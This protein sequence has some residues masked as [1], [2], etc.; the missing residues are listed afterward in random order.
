VEVVES[1]CVQTKHD[2][3]LVLEDWSASIPKIE[4]QETSIGRSKMKCSMK[5]Q[6][7][8]KLADHQVM[9]PPGI[10][11][12]SKP[13]DCTSDTA[14]PEG[15]PLEPF[16]VSEKGALTYATQVGNGDE[17]NE[18][19][20]T[21]TTSTKEPAVVAEV[22]IED[23]DFTTTVLAD[24]GKRVDPREHGGAIFNTNSMIVPADTGVSGVIELAGVHRGKGRSAF[25]IP[26]Q[27][28]EQKKT[29]DHNHEPLHDPTVPRLPWHPKI[30]PYRFIVFLIPLAIG[31][32]KA[33]SSQKGNVTIPITLEWISGIVVFLV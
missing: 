12:S 7:E 14:L 27:S 4:T 8:R 15:E 3:A 9:T 11:H 23:G 31:T 26:L 5:P 6:T 22:F 30:S 32:A 13:P 2:G 17:G 20:I 21:S 18:F 10:D 16:S 1:H 33:I 24:K 25:R 19:V 28:L 29:N